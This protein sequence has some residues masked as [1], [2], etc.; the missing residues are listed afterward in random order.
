MRRILIGL[1]A[2]VFVM[3]AVVVVRT[4]ALAPP[5]VAQLKPTPV[6]AVDGMDVARHLAAVVRF[7][8]VSY[9]YDV[10]DADKKEAAKFAELDGLRAYLERT[11]PNLHRVAKREIFG[12]SL[13]FVW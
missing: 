9:G 10:I 7:K 5:A 3:A 11:Y 4:L 1:A 13:L 8:T 12:K 6:E 2:V